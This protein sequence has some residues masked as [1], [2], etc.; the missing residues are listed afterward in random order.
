MPSVCVNG[1]GLSVDAG[2]L[3]IDW[4][5]VGAE[6]AQA[7]AT[8][9]TGSPTRHVEEWLEMAAVSLQY[10]NTSC[11]PKIVEM[12]GFTPF[13]RMRLGPG[14][15]WIR[16]FK[17]AWAI[18]ADPGRPTPGN[19]DA[20]VRANWSSSMPSGSY[21]EVSQPA[22][23]MPYLARVEPGQTLQMRHLFWWR[24]DAY[25]E[26]GYN[27]VHLPSLRVQYIAWPAAT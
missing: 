8:G 27:W 7:Y 2:S 10:T 19:L 15:N 1:C 3:S 5:A 16:A 21:H 12:R 11:R 18:N 4:R 26:S 24:T 20:F 9:W 25:T 14:N 22:E 13:L 17:L 23:T 6:A